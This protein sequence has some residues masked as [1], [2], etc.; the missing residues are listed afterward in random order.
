M[1]VC[2]L[3][4]ISYVWFFETP[5]NVACQTPLSVGFSRQEYW[6]GWLWPPAGHLLDPETSMRLLHCRQILYRWAPGE[7]CT[8]CSLCNIPSFPSRATFCLQSIILKHFSK[9][10]KEKYPDDQKRLFRTSL[11]ALFAFPWSPVSPVSLQSRLNCDPGSPWTV[12]NGV[13]D[14][15][16][17]TTKQAAGSCGRHHFTSFQKCVLFSKM[18]GFLYRDEC[19][20]AWEV[21]MRILQGAGGRPSLRAF[22]TLSSRDPLRVPRSP[23]GKWKTEKARW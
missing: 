22:S 2:V 8:L 16:G 1:H 13:P 18:S 7:A 23:L 9:S 4:R 11:W 17:L 5:W 6:R 19:L 20:A 21:F 3:S 15:S 14:S 12:A 10:S